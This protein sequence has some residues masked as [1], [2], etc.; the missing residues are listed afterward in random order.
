MLYDP[1]EE[2][3]SKTDLVKLDDLINHKD[4]FVTRPPYQRKTVW[5]RD[6]QKQLIDTL[7]RRFYVP[8][9]VLRKIIINGNHSRWEVID[10]QQ[11]ITAVQKF[12]EN[13]FTV[14]ETLK[15]LDE[16]MEQCVG[17]KYKDLPQD[18]QRF[19]RELS[20]QSTQIRH[21]QSKD[22]PKH[23]KIA[24]DI[25]WRLQ[26]GE[27]LNQMEV[28]HAVLT[29]RVRHFLVQY[30]DD[31]S[32]D[33]DKYVPVDENPHKHKF[34][35]LIKA[36]NKRMQHLSLMGRLLLIEVN[37]GYTNIK[38]DDLGN[39]INEEKVRKEE[40][41]TYSSEA[42]AKKLLRCLNKVYE[43]FNK[44][45]DRK[46]SWPEYLIVSFY[47][48]IR[49]MD[50]FYVWDDA[51]DHL[52][53]FLTEEFYIRWSRHDNEDIDIHVF[54]D[55]RQQ[56]ESDLCDRDLV[57]RQLFFTFVKEKGKQIRIKDANRYFNEAER[58]QIYR[59]GNGICVMC[60]AEGKSEK[61]QKVPWGEYE[62]DHIVPWFKGGGTDPDENAQVLCRYHNRAKG[63]R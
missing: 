36:D 22:N 4:E 28:L 7:F 43:V 5:S 29:S 38:D 45:Q 49:H 61:D 48:L 47:L 51:K 9:L 53:E 8:G 33:Y 62:A 6:K 24:T 27:S 14:P 16:K 20:F 18:V 37:K 3:E 42:P 41:F 17:K 40:Y 12:M 58:I 44:E 1:R 26:Q 32:F 23:Q 21:I 57:I 19:F 35:S 25:F 2:Y 55:N 60:K 39:L 46:Y 63:A 10:G 11:R 34:F 52:Y 50:E 31:V 30:A 59:K 13:E 15:D 56:A 54:R